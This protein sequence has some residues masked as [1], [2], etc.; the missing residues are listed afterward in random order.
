MDPA[1]VTALGTLVAALLLDR[2]GEYPAALHP[3]VW[4]GWLIS[5]LLRLAPAAGWWRQL[6]FGAL[7]TA[8]VVAFWTAATVLVLR[9]ASPVPFLGLLPGVLLLKASFALRELGT[10]AERVRGPVEV[11]DLPAARAA[12]RSLCSRDPSQ[13]DGEA[14]LAATIQSLAE[15][16]SDSFVAP[17]FYYVVA[18]VPGAVAYRVINTLDAMIGYR[19][20]Y[21]ALGKAAAR[22]DDLAN[23]VPARLTAGLLLLAGLLTGRDVRGGWRVLRRDGGKTPSPN[24]GRPMAVMAGLLGVRLEKKGAYVLG[25]PAIPLTPAAVRQAWR[26]VALVGWLIAALCALGIVGLHY[27]WLW[28]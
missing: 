19:G 2:L 10:A 1:T 16:A 11:G 4:M 24:G 8:G 27:V 20:K 21:E 9:Y 7:L 13:L 25:D 23:L 17:L 14:L 5:A 15:N 12:L 3:V 6:L 28:H 26:L 22:L 18:G